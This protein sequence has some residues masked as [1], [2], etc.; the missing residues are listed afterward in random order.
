MKSQLSQEISKYDSLVIEKYNLQTQMTNAIKTIN[1]LESDLEAYIS[2]KQKLEATVNDLH[3]KFSVIEHKFSDV[4]TIV[5][6][7]MNDHDET[8]PIFNETDE[9]SKEKLSN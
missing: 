5:N 3:D 7:E 1:N 2:E 4:V 8:N 9:E 6:K